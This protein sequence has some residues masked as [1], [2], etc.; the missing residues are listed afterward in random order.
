MWKTHSNTY[1]DHHTLGITRNGQIET[2]LGRIVAN[3]LINAFSV[4]PNPY[5]RP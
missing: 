1:V 4:V 5:K 2:Q 3:T